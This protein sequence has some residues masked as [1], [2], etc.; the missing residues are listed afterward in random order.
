MNFSLKTKVIFS[1]CGI[2]ASV[3]AINAYIH[4]RAFQNEF[5][6]AQ[7][8]RS[9]AL[10]QEIVGDVRRLGT[11]MSIE[12]MAGMLGRHCYELHELNEKEGIADISVITR[13]GLLVAH[14]NLSEPLGQAIGSTLVRAALATHEVVTLKDDAIFHTLIPIDSQG[15]KISAVIDVS[16]KK[17]SYDHAVHDIIAFSILMFI[18]SGLVSSLITALLLNKIF[19]QLEVVMNDLRESKIFTQ[20]ILDNEKYRNYSLE[21][22]AS[23]YPLAFVLENIALGVEKL[24]PQMLCSI[25][26]LDKSGE[27]LI[28]GAAP[29][30]SPVYNQAI[31]GVKIGL[32]VGS[33]GTAA[34]T[35]QRVLVDDISTHPYW[36]PYKELAAQAG[37]GA[38]WS[39]PINSAKGH[40][41]GTFAIYHR[42]ANAPSGEDILL[43]EK[44]ARLAS[45]AIEKEIAAS[46]IRE[47]E[48]R[49]RLVVESSNDGIGVTQD[50]K[51]KFVN[52]ALQSL[53]GY[54]E[55]EILNSPF[56]NF[57]QPDDQALVKSNYQK[58]IKGEA[59]QQRY[60]LRLLKKDGGIVWVEMSG[61]KI[62]WEG[63]PATLN[64]ISDISERK[65]MEDQVQQLAFFDPLT[66]LPNRRLLDDRITQAMAASKR[67]NLYCALMFLDLDNF[68]PLNDTY[69]HDVGDLL[70]I[71]AANRLKGCIREVDTVAR[72]GGDEFVVM[73]CELDNDRIAATGRARNIAEKI[74][75]TLSAPYLLTVNTGDKLG[76]IVEHHC[77]ASI[78]FTVFVNHE[79]S[80]EEI[81]KHADNAMYQAKTAGR[82]SIRLYEEQT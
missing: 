26:L 27:H 25:L 82:N 13:D 30:L 81:L 35:N 42:Q 36:V 41:L 5:F 63:R 68:K 72:F 74:L 1:V 33:C 40:V 79:G 37:L 76:K 67:N 21:L 17:S 52:P 45:I 14:S 80:R 12:D 73:L 19:G 71:E 49:Y 16:W 39:Q 11:T 6:S 29:S 38:C 69:G 53:V 75:S 18:L 50:A 51:L 4:V 3:M 47:S 77:T 70:L 44:T 61:V 56:V 2:V 48:Q 43:I 46:E 55:K 32:G 15:K 78:G 65:Q 60:Q 62:D 31:N 54:S 7:A 20:A 24:H 28:T 23:D 64:F 59:A 58:R 9:K 22:I 57:I 10:V 8:Q 66:N 34:F